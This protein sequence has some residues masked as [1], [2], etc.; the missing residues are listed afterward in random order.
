MSVIMNYYRHM[1]RSKI[2]FDFLCFLPCEESYEEEIEALG[3]NVFYIPKPSNIIAIRRLRYFMKEHAQ[4]YTW[5]HNHE[6][7]LSF[8][9]KPLAVHYG[10]A[11]FIIHSHAT[12]YSDRSLPAFR[13]LIACIPI[14][15][16]DCF[17]FACSKAAGEFLF[18]NCTNGRNTFTIIPNAIQKQLFMYDAGLRTHYRRLFALEHKFVIGHVG[19]FVPQKN[20]YFIVSVFHQVL[21]SA[22]DTQLILIG[23]GPLRDNV[24]RYVQNLGISSNVHFLGQRGDI[25]NILQAMDIFLLPSIYEGLPMSCLEAQASGLPCIVSNTI[26]SEVCFGPHTHMLSLSEKERWVEKCLE[27]EVNFFETPSST[28]RSFPNLLPDIE[29]EAKKLA[30][31][32]EMENFEL[33]SI[34]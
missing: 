9:L 34:Y 32:Y 1:D 21:I 17:H 24:M 8:L 29:I 27:Y 31:F 25:C 12:R 4:Q 26:T 10:V 20:H 15:F 14:R 3:G 7:Y 19:R 23:D 2:Q 28:Q 5:L 33:E 16:M 22:P 30:K 18:H 13:N 11:H 6:V